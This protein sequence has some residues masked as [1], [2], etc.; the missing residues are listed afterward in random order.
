[1][2]SA[3]RNV[4]PGGPQVTTAAAAQSSALTVSDLTARI[5]GTLEPRFAGVWVTGEISGYRGP[6]GQSGHIY[7]TLKD[8]WSQ[9]P[10]TIWR[11]TAQR[12]GFRLEE[13]MGVNVF[14]NVEVY[15]PRGSY[16]LIATRLE[17]KGVGALQ[18]AFRQLFERLRAEGLFDEGRKRPMPVH[19][20]GIGIVTAPTG[21]AIR[22]MLTIIRRRDPRMT[23]VIYPARVQGEG[24]KEEIV[25]GIEFLNRHREALGID[26]IIAGRGGGSLE[27]LWAFNEEVVARAICGSDLPVVSAV[28][29]EI[30]TTVA[31]YVA[32]MRAATPSEAAERV[33]PLLE[34]LV[35]AT[36]RLEEQLRDA[37]AAAVDGRRRMLETLGAQLSAHAPL[38]RLRERAQA[39]DERGD[40]MARAMRLH[41][42]RARG[43]LASGSSR[44]EGLS[45]LRVL[46]RGY[47]VTRLPDG[48]V[49][50][51]VND[52]HPGSLI[53][54]R[55]GDGTVKSRVETAHTD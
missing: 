35:G 38:R 15:A 48:R 25:A 6:H 22:D 41:V 28:G 37:A 4:G 11:T 47:S 51:S 16:Q 18:L 1:M 42:E 54:T 19:P 8:A 55:L 32:D 20:R 17:P 52:A 29:H 33:V 34:E 50:K 7:C 5:K 45:P 9:V 39:L 21:A 2:P 10:L 12:L 36:E 31:D 23:V 49:L 14:G 44:L 3:A 30:D 40:R 53:A 46:T 27:D 24:A 43:L 13:G 26:L